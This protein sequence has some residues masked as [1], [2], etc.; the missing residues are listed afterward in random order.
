MREILY[1]GKRVDNG[2]WV[3]GLLTIMWGQY[4]IISPDDENTAYPID[5]ETVG[6]YTGLIDKN[7]TKIFENYILK[8]ISTV[9]NKKFNDCGYACGYTSEKR[10]DYAVVLRNLTT[11]GYKLKVYHNGKYKRISKFSVGNLFCYEAEVIGNIHDNPELLE[12]KE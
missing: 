9:K 1:R 6:E 10:K 8:I 7:G 4:H 12:E 11:G 3:E 2:E 5:P